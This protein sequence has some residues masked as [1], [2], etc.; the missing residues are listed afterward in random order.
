[1]IVNG[2]LVDQNLAGRHVV[3]RRECLALIA[4]L[5][6]LH[7]ANVAVH[8]PVAVLAPADERDVVPIVNLELAVAEF[9]RPEIIGLPI[10]HRRPFD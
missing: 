4:F 5:G 3:Q 2:V 7:V 9:V 6:R 10:A 8:R 1:M